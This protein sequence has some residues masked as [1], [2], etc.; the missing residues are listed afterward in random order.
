MMNN[1]NCV[2]A[3]ECKC[4]AWKPII[5]GALVAIGFTFLLN[6]FSVAI[7]LTAFTTN[8]EGVE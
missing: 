4:I 6:I 8:S 3:P 2:H 7:G 5:A 1:E